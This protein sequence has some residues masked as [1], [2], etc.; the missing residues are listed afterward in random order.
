M[1]FTN[2]LYHFSPRPESLIDLAN[3]NISKT[4]MFVRK[5]ENPTDHNR[6]MVFQVG[7]FDLRLISPDRKQILL[8]KQLKDVATCMQVR[9]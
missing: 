4:E 1:N 7:R 3:N 8:H 9:N 6:T 2:Y 5:L